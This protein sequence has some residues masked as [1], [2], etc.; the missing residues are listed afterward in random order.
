M[1]V[2]WLISFMIWLLCLLWHLIK[3]SE[4][5]IL[6]MW[7]AIGLQWAAVFAELIL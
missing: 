5:S 3:P 7:L 4:W 6:C 1:N 2:V